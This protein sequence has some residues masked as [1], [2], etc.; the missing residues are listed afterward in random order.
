MGETSLD[1]VVTVSHGWVMGGEISNVDIVIRSEWGRFM[2][3]EIRRASAEDLS[4][5]CTTFARSFWDD[6]VMRWL[7]PDDDVFRDG[8]VMQGFF[9]RVMAHDCTL[10]TPDVAAFSMWIPP[11]RPEL[12]V[13]TGPS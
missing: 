4:L 6:P 10:V 2:G 13:D 9:Q 1:V 7:F 11:T 3:L 12:D 5:I 8:T